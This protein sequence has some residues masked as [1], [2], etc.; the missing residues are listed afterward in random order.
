[1]A[2]RDGCASLRVLTLDRSFRPED[3]VTKDVGNA[4]VKPHAL[5]IVARTTP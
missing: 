1:V 3:V 4:Q 5:Q 2:R